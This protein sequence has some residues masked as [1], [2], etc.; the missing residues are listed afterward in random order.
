MSSPPPSGIPAAPSS[1]ASPFSGLIFWLNYVILYDMNKRWVLEGTGEHLLR[2]R[3]LGSGG[4]PEETIAPLLT[5]QD[6]C[7]RLRK[8]R[9]QVYRY[10][11]AGRLSA[12]ARILGQWL[13]DPR[14]LDRLRRA[15]LP[16]AFR[17][18]FWD[19]PLSS[20]SVETH[21]D[22]ILGRLLE[23]GDRQALRWVF[24]TYPK[25]SLKEFLRR[26][27]VEILSKKN[28]RFYALLLGLDPNLQSR[29]RWRH[30]GRRW[31]GIS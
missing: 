16:P 18:F 10:L 6:V 12:C 13:F 29:R 26:R 20:L 8:S 19:T 17:R 24:R 22:F 31:G 11:R 25:A 23:W 3:R 7:R 27:G 28:W 21:R 4:H 14:A 15:S 5:V 2:L 30:A 9:R 1:S